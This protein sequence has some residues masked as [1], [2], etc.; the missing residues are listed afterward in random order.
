[1]TGRQMDVLIKKGAPVT[2]RDRYGDKFVATF[3]SRERRTA[4]T[5]T[6]GRFEFADLKI[7]KS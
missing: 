5:A 7:V 1:M 2:V 4:D 3:I 6:G